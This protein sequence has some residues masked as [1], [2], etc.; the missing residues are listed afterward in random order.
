[1][2]AQERAKILVVESNDRTLGFFARML[3]QQYV[4]VTAQTLE[5]G[6]ELLQQDTF[7]A[8]LAG[9]SLPWLGCIDFLQQVQT[10]MPYACR[11]LLGT[12]PQS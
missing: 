12:H 11:I 1:M 7:A 8:V 9:D 6:Q 5:R 4:V 10:V 3:S 2:T